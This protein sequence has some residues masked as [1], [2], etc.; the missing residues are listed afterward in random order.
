MGQ[1]DQPRESQSQR[2]R[3]GEVSNNLRFRRECDPKAYPNYRQS[4]REPAGSLHGRRF[5]TVKHH[6]FC[7]ASV[8]GIKPE[9]R[10]NRTMIRTSSAH[11][12]VT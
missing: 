7:Q 4:Q 11:T 8:R 5:S 6:R 2:G 10:T 9:G 12:N 1:H 3:V